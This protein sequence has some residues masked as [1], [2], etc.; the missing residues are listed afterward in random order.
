MWRGLSHASELA[1]PRRCIKVTRREI[2]ASF[3]NA[4][5][6]TQL[7]TKLQLE[8]PAALKLARRIRWGS[9]GCDPRTRAFAE[10][11]R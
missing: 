11:T 4:I 9:L 2:D 10:E 6:A 7:S 1:D 8:C 3:S 5:A